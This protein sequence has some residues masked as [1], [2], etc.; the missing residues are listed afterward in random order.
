[1][2]DNKNRW[3]FVTMGL[4][5]LLV[6]IV[7]FGPSFV[8]RLFAG[9]FDH[10]PRI[11]AH[12]LTMFGWLFLF[13]AQAA[14][15]GSG[16]FV[17]HKRLG[18]VSV[19]LFI[20]LMVSAVTASI[21]G[22]LKP[23]P[24]P[25]ERLIDN[26]FFLQLCAFVLTPI[27]YALALLERLRR[28][29]YHKRYMLLLTF[30][31]IEAAASRMTYLP[32]MGHDETFLIAQYLYLDLLLVPLFLFDIRTLGRVSR[33]TFVGAGMLFIYQIVAVIVWDSPAWLS[34]V[35]GIESYLANWFAS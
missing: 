21:N 27:L 6:S 22:L 20:F 11:Y 18:I 24:P 2:T 17:L 34:T 23:L 31:L 28:P 5:F 7:G 15:I 26:I 33:A 35:N 8:F 16:R 32:G 3:F 30:F 12:A 9:D 13:I 25:V 10:P 4:V 29:E 19:V 14:L 1:M